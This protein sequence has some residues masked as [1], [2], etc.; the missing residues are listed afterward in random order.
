MFGAGGNNQKK[1]KT[2]VGEYA[3]R[4]SK[5]LRLLGKNLYLGFKERKI[6][7]KPNSTNTNF[8]E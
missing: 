2:W 3:V 7:I 4:Y 5:M 1:V 6:K 8:H